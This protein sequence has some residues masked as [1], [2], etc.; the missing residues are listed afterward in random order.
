MAKEYRIVAKGGDLRLTEAGMFGADLGELH[1]TLSGKL[2]T[3]NTFSGDY[4]L[5]D[6][7]GFF[8]SGERYKMTRPDGEVVYLKKRA[9]SS[10]TYAVD[11][12]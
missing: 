3:R 4:V 1:K 2:K 12:D 7:S 10:D 6:V 9:F 8:S 5:E 11:G